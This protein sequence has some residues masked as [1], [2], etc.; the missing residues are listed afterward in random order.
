MRQFFAKARSTLTNRGGELYVDNA[1]MIIIAVVIGSLLLT[2]LYALFNGLILPGLVERIQ[3]MLSSPG[4]GGSDGGGGQ[5][6][7]L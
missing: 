4:G 6:V 5:I 1:I 3:N 2:G 7:F